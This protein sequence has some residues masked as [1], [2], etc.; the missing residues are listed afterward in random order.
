MENNAEP[1]RSVMS[2]DKVFWQVKLFK[3]KHDLGLT[4]RGRRL[5]GCLVWRA[6]SS[7]EGAETREGRSERGPGLMQGEHRH[8]EAAR[9]FG[10]YAPAANCSSPFVRGELCVRFFCAAGAA[11]ATAAVVGAAGLGAKKREMDA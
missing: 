6:C 4:D 9:Q 10:R 7:P 2:M 8:T 1:C 3:S 11:A 5:V